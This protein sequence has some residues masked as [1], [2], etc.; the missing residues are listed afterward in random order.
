ML[1]ASIDVRLSG[2]CVAKLFS[3]PEW[4]I[5]IQGR[6]QA[7]NVDSKTR[8]FGLIIA[9]SQRRHRAEAVMPTSNYANDPAQTSVVFQQRV[10]EATPAPSRGAIVSPLRIA[11]RVR[12]ERPSDHLRAW[13][14]GVSQRRA[15]WRNVAHSEIRGLIAIGTWVTTTSVSDETR[16]SMRLGPRH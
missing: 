1:V 8:S 7:R 15:S 10:L 2:E 5:L 12:L 6:A 11:R 4:A 3:R 14:W 16:S 13:G 9:R